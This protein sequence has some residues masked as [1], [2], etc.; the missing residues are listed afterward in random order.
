MN[1]K[2]QLNPLH[3]QPLQYLAIWRRLVYEYIWN[4]KWKPFHDLEKNCS[5]TQAEI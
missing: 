2:K 5:P 4:C 3:L 1:I